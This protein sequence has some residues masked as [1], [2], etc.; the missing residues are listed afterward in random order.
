M[1]ESH[2]FKIGFYWVVHLHQR[3]R[4]KEKSKEERKKGVKWIQ[5][6]KEERRD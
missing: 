4:I 1:P 5:R 3:L 6:E 2:I